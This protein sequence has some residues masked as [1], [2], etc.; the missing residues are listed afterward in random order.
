MRGW[1]RAYVSIS[2]GGGFRM[3][4]F[5]LRRLVQAAAAIVIVV[6]LYFLGLARLQAGDHAVP[7]FDV[8]SFTDVLDY[9]GKL[10]RGD[11]GYSELQQGRTVA[12]RIVPAT[13]NTA[14]L[15]VLAMA[16]QLTLG[17]TAGVLA[18]VTRRRF[19]DVLINVITLTVLS[20]P[21][22]VVGLLLKNTFAGTQL[23]GATLFANVPTAFTNEGS[24]LQ[25]AILPAVTV[26]VA[27]LAFITRLARTAMLEVLAADYIRTAR[28]KGL[29]E[30]R[31][32]WVHALRNA[33]VP[34]IT[35]A[36]VALGLFLGGTFLVE[37]LFDYQGLGNRLWIAFAFRPDIPV[38]KAGVVYLTVM[39]MV[40]SAL[41]D[42]L[43]RWL[44]P[45]VRLH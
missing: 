28:S 9:L 2:E 27:D 20:V 16:I 34:V 5:V 42:I 23:F 38:L 8:F 36:T 15:A 31:V 18:A 35:Y 26:A 32:I 11:L 40:L 14:R 24:W 1:T 10:V 29:T 3:L 44:D 25:Q 45:R 30:R 39:F 22:I 13:W 21:I 43:C 7:L 33:L 6:T 37:I 12:E 41:M 19:V 17:L 4:I